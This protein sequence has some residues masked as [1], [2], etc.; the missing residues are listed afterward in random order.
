MNFYKHLHEIK[1]AIMNR[2]ELTFHHPMEGEKS[3]LNNMNCTNTMINNNV[4]KNKLSVY[5]AFKNK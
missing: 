1:P 2:S 4:H 3:S 5:K